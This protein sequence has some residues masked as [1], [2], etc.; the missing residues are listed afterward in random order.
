MFHIYIVLVSGYSAAFVPARNSVHVLNRNVDDNMN[1]FVQSQPKFE[2]GF[3][4]NY[5][6]MVRIKFAY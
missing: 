4:P 5:G 3:I 1:S 2:R 6:M